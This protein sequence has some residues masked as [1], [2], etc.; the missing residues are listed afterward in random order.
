[1]AAG[2]HQQQQSTDA[3]AGCETFDFR[4]QLQK[5][6][7][8]QLPD[9]PYEATA[10]LETIVDP[11]GLSN[12]G[13]QLHRDMLKAGQPR[14]IATVVAGN[15]GRPAGAC[16]FKDGTIRKLHAEHTTQEED[17]VS[18]WMTT[19]C[20]NKGRPLMPGMADGGHETA[21]AVYQATIFKKW[22]MLD[23]EGS[24][25]KTVQHVSAR[26]HV[27]PKGPNPPSWQAATAVAAAAAA[28]A[29]CTQ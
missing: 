29:A 28:A 6:I 18:N 26:A 15:S 16:G 12:V 2:Q 4:D 11:N 17:V 23:L 8:V 10:R 1:V 19:A 5:R 7:R 3:A 21:N 20:H 22:G 25:K 27:P 9:P 24:S 13:A 14:S